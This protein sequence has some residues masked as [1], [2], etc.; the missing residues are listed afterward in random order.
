M[1]KTSFFSDSWTEA[2]SKVLA[3][4]LPFITMGLINRD[5]PALI[6]AAGSVGFVALIAFLVRIGILFN[7]QPSRNDKLDHIMNGL[8]FPYIFGL[9]FGIGIE[10]G[11]PSGWYGVWF[12]LFM[13]AWTIVAVCIKKR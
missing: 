11:E 6:I 5:H 3:A 1:D 12:A 4:T 13:A 10:Y 2:F 9:S 7:K 8:T